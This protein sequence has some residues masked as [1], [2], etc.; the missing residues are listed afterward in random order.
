VII[1]VVVVAVVLLI[2]VALVALRWRSIAVEGRPQIGQA[3][4]MIVHQSSGFA[5]PPTNS[6]DSDPAGLGLYDDT[7]QDNDASDFEAPPPH[8][9]IGKAL[10]LDEDNY[11]DNLEI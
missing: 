2:V 9:P 4:V 3:G 10:Q 6:P 7:T 1:V 11:V 8:T 5:E